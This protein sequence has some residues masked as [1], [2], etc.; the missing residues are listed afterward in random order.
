MNQG[1]IF[2]PFF[3]VMLLTL[4]VWLYMYFLRL[5]FFRR[6]KIPPQ[7]VST[8]QKVIA[9]VP[10]EINYPSENLINLF[11]LPVLFYPACIFLYITGQVNETYLVL[12]YSFF[13]FRVIHSV[14]HCTYNN[15]VHRF[16]AYLLSSFMLWAIIIMAFIDT[17]KF[18]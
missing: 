4:S 13:V 1:S 2:I 15:V 7:S 6:E 9:T 16:F 5:S 14:I 8:T 10:E 12:A 18:Q 17:V 11:E 3:G